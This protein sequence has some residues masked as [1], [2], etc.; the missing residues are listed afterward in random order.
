VRGQAAEPPAVGRIMDYFM[1]T[2]KYLIAFLSIIPIVGSCA[3]SQK[4]IITSTIITQPSQIPT[5]IYT[6]RDKSTFLSSISPTF[7]EIISP[8]T[9]L[10]R[11]ETMTITQDNSNTIDD[12]CNITDGGWQGYNYVHKYGYIDSFVQFDVI[13]CQ[14]K[15]WKIHLWYSPSQYDTIYTDASI[16]IIDFNYIY[17]DP[18][19]SLTIQG[20]FN[21]KTTCYG[22]VTIPWEYFNGKY[23]GD[24]MKFDWGAYAII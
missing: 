12:K 8:S 19:K 9:V 3:I 13:N 10:L 1:K 5:I 16:P 22:S 20:W 2:R 21:T 11:T 14:I 24:K 15:S 6:P 7:S 23:S 17:N 4:S 18:N